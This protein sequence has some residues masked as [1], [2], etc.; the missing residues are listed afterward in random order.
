MSDDDDLKRGISNMALVKSFD[1]GIGDPLMVNSNL[2]SPPR[3]GSRRDRRQE[4]AKRKKQQREE[5]S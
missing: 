5:E 2:Q 4:K 3:K 1:V